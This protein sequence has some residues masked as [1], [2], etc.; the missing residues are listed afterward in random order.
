M[1][2]HSF[3]FNLIT[4]HYN[5]VSANPALYVGVSRCIPCPV[6]QMEVGSVDVGGGGGVG[7]GE[8]Q[9]EV[10]DKRGRKNR[11]RRKKEIRKKDMEKE[12]EKER[13]GRTNKT[14]TV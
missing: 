5:C 7:S 12:R 3:V 10:K 14:S 2:M 1:H 9:E 11:S 4:E 8:G 13:Y 6:G